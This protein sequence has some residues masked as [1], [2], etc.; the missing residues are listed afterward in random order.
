MGKAETIFMRIW[1]TLMLLGLIVGYFIKEISTD[2]FYM[3]MI[4]CGI[5]LTLINVGD[6]E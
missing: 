2:A 6:K 4:G 1:Y 5:W 3:G